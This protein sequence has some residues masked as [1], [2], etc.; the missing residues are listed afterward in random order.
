MSL[1]L[2][3]TPARAIPQGCEWWFFSNHVTGFHAQ[4]CVGEACRDAGTGSVGTD[5]LFPR[6]V[7]SKRLGSGC[8]CLCVW[9]GRRRAETLATCGK[10]VWLCLDLRHYT[11]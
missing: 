3:T 10:A 11:Q 7:V 9:Y 4:D 1:D 2:T 5:S 6:V 8:I